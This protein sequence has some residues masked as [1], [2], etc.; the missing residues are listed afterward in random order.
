MIWDFVSTF[1]MWVSFRIRLSIP[2]ESAGDI[3]REIG[4]LL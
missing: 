1:A 4:S 2:A 3:T